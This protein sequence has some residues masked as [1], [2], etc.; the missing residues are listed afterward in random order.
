MPIFRVLIIAGCL[1]LLSGGDFQLQVDSHRVEAIGDTSELHFRL[2]SLSR[3]ST[4]LGTGYYL[5]EISG[6]SSLKYD[7]RMMK[8]TVDSLIVNSGTVIQPVVGNQIFQSLLGTAPPTYTNRRFSRIAASYAFITARSGYQLA[9]YGDGQTAAII[10]LRPDFASRFSGIMGAERDAAGDWQITGEIDLHLENSW[11]TAGV[12]DVL[13]RRKN[14]I[15]QNI[16]LALAEPHPFGSKLGFAV[17]FWQDLENGLFVRQGQK[18]SLLAAGTGGSRWSIG[19]SRKEINPTDRGDSAGVSSSLNRQL[20][21]GNQSDRRN[22]RWLPSAGTYWQLDCGLGTGTIAGNNSA[23]ASFQLSAGWYGTLNPAFYFH[24]GLW[25][26][27]NHESGDVASAVSFGGIKTLR[28][29]SEDLFTADWVLVPRF[30]VF[31]RAGQNLRLFSF[32]D[33]AVQERYTPLP[34]GVGWGLIQRSRSTILRI[35]YG[36][37]RNDRLNQGKIHLQIINRL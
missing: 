10:N 32:L 36:L 6:D 14:S 5:V 37:G 7:S 19:L 8:I 35:S 13:W 27:G 20:A 16:L 25:G 33:T 2:D 17:R 11:R 30:E 4:G 22:D 9:R 15:S 28:G 24:L 3:R 1:A 29:Y 26:R 31:Y 21:V 18:L 34:L 12:L 23:T